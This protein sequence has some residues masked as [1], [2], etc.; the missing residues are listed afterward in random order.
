MEN[1]NI[2]GYLD[3]KLTSMDVEAESMQDAI[4]I[5]MDTNGDHLGPIVQARKNGFFMDGNGRFYGV[6]EEI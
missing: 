2:I 4:N 5:L 6:A 3:G 1:Y